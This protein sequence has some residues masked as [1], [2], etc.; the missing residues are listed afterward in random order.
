MGTDFFGNF[1]HIKQ[2]MEGRWGNERPLI[3]GVAWLQGRALLFE[4]S[5]SIR[6][7]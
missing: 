6:T 1:L 3:M 7:L 5:I 2:T 4:K